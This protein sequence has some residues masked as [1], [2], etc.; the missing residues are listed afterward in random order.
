M[1]TEY[2]PGDPVANPEIGKIYYV[3]LK[4]GTETPVEIK[5]EHPM[6]GWVGWTI[7]KD[8]HVYLDKTSNFRQAVPK[9]NIKLEVTKYKSVM[10]GKVGGPNGPPCAVL[11]LE[12]NQLPHYL[13][14]EFEDAKQVVVNLLKVLKSGGDEIS[15]ELYEAFQGVFKRKHEAKEAHGGH[16]EDTA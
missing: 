2:I 3:T 15:G 5:R 13:A 12:V 10:L 7:P 6:G 14:M 1:G 11:Q 9:L 4:D 16:K 8:L